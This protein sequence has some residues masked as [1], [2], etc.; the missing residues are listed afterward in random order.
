MEFNPNI[1]S[2]LKGN[3]ID[4]DSGLLALLALHHNLDAA[5]IIP[6]ELLRKINLT[7]IIEKDYLSKTVKWNMPLFQG[8]ESGAFDWCGEWLQPFK[9]IGRQAITPSVIATTVKRMKEWFAK[10]P[11]YRKDDV[12]AARDLYFR[13]E[14]PSG[15]FV[16]TSTKFIQEGDVSML[17]IWCERLTEL[18]EAPKKGTGTFKGRMM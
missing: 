8:T 6:E 17:L 7:K 14:Q 13:T 3:G 5:K 1:K 15:K 4:I 16:K 12:F 2:I 10:H 11:E 9:Q 18:K